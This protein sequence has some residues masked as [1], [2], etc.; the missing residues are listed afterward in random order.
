MRNSKTKLLTLTILIFLIL[1]GMTVHVYA[2]IPQ[3]IGPLQAL[4]QIL[5]QLLGLAAAA[6]A[7]A[8]MTWRMWL[9]HILNRKGLLALVI[10]GLVII[11]GIG[12]FLLMYSPQEA[13]TAESK[14]EA[15]KPVTKTWKTFRAVLKRTGNV[16]GQTLPPSPGLV[17]KFSD[18][19]V[20]MI[21]FSSSPAFVE[22]RVYA[23]SGE[24][25]VFS[26]RGYVYC[27]DAKNAE[28]I[29]KFPTEKQ[30]FSSPTVAYGKV[31]IGE[32]LHH[33]FD[34]KLY[35]IDKDSGEVVWEHQ[36]TSHVES[37]PFITDGKVFVG[38][39]E[40]GVY[41]LNAQTG[42]VKWHYEGV[43]VDSSPAVWLGAVYFGTAYGER[44]IY[45][46]DA[47]SGEKLWKAKV[48]YH[49]WGSPSISSGE[50]YFGIGSSTFVEKAEEP[51]GGIVCLNARTGK[52]KWFYNVEATV[53]SA[54]SIAEKM[55]IFGAHNGT[56]YAVSAD[57]GKLKWKKKV[58][59]PVLSS[60]AVVRNNVYAASKKGYIY[61]LNLK[62][63]NLR[64]KYDTSEVGKAKIL[65]SPAIADGKMFI[66]LAR[67]YLLCLGE[68]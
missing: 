33:D 57:S 41:C 34:C 17:W 13:I 20:K 39:G 12:A 52:E 37:T 10:S 53:L 9:S 7:T 60:P 18:P 25:S 36:T 24:A 65:S 26:S 14:G 63:G 51:A 42:R 40:D 47:E 61:C 11:V 1:T 58:D 54:A 27:L 15:N 38:A 48:D 30:I 55:I 19:E 68:K 5:P 44:A 46:V 3:L 2:V 62:N 67:K 31:Y 6:I 35:C 4:V 23:G 28:I 49:V 59:S 56:V 16:D 21:D 45:C 50:V 8:W 64:W 29:W 66:G 32:G 43:H 22:G